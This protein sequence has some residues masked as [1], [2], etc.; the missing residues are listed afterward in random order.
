[1]AMNTTSSVHGLS[2]ESAQSEFQQQ[3]LTS[4]I[5]IPEVSRIT[6]LDILDYAAYNCNEHYRAIAYSE[7]EL[8]NQ[9]GILVR[10]GH[11]VQQ[12]VH[13]GKLEELL[14]KNRCV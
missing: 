12:L 14:E 4:C 3:G 8:F 13:R 9:D 5:V 11:G 6:P 10:I 2:I 1:M 7:S